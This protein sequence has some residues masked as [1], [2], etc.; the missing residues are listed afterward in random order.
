VS[1]LVQVSSF[2]NVL[3]EILQ[4]QEILRTCNYEPFSASG[5][6][7]PRPPLPHSPTTSLSG[8]GITIFLVTPLIRGKLNNSRARGYTKPH[9][10]IHQTLSFPTQTQKKESGLGTRLAAAGA[11]STNTRTEDFCVFTA[12]VFF[13]LIRY[14]SFFLALLH[15][16]A[17]SNT[18]G[19]HRFTRG[20]R[21]T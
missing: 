1:M 20:S 18:L 16:S 8:P 11:L 19:V 6:A 13:V 3:L 4:F 2:I 21:C 14:S 12:Q 9:T 10:E 15:C 7:A 5:G 17:L